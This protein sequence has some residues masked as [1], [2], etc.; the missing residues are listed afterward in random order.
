[1]TTRSGRSLRLGA[2]D[3]LIEELECAHQGTHVVDIVSS[4]QGSPPPDHRLEDARHHEVVVQVHH[5]ADASL[6]SSTPVHVRAQQ[7]PY[8]VELGGGHPPP[9]PQAA[10]P[11]LPPPT[12]ITPHTR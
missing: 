9:P 5:P 3:A 4:D 10:S 8:N 1:M 12:S 11:A 6:S 7:H 2:E